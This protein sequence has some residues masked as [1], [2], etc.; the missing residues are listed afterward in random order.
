MGTHK[1]RIVNSLPSSFRPVHFYKMAAFALQ[2]AGLPAL[3]ARPAARKVRAPRAVAAAPKRAVVK[4]SVKE[5]TKAVAAVSTSAVAFAAEAA[6]AQVMELN[7]VVDVAAVDTTIYYF[8]ILGGVFG[9]TV[10]IYVFL[11]KGINLI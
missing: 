3:A 2:A 4:A 6:N 10:A 8:G 5:S 11:R 1:Y 7:Q 9:A